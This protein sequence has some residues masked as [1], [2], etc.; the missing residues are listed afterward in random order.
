[1]EGLSCLTWIPTKDLVRRSI[2]ELS[3]ACAPVFSHSLGVSLGFHYVAVSCM[4]TTTTKSQGSLCLNTQELL[5]QYDPIPFPKCVGRA[6]SRLLRVC[7]NSTDRHCI[8]EKLISVPQK[9]LLLICGKAQPVCSPVEMTCG[10]G[11]S[12]SNVW[13]NLHATLS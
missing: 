5:W 2:S 8:C 4:V 9:D 1:M 3:T 11:C 10:C 13:H 7:G 12:S 6:F